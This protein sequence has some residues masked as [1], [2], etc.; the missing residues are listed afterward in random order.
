MY[1]L[2]EYDLLEHPYDSCKKSIL[3]VEDSKAMLH[4]LYTKLSEQYNVFPAFSGIEALKMLND[5]PAVPHLIL[6]DIMMDKMDGFHFA[7]IIS[8]Q[9]KYSHIPIIFLTAKS[10]PADKLKGLSSGAIDYISKPFSFNLLTCKIK[11]ILNNMDKQHQVIIKNTM[12]NLGHQ[13]N[14]GEGPIK[15]DPADFDQKCRLYRLTTRE[16]E[17]VN[18]I[19]E[20]AQYKGIAKSLYISSGTVTKHIQNIFGKVGVSNK[21]ALINRLSK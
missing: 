21:T 2:F 18:L 15:D 17:I 14:E 5:L 6:S 19:R 4:F 11:N 12:L 20:G 9:S 7:K 16:I 13:R 3:L 10:M 8:E 1:D